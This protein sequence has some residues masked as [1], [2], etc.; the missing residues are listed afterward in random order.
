MRI[1]FGILI[2][3]EAAA[4]QNVTVDITPSHVANTFSPMHALGSG[5]DAVGQGVVDQVYTPSNI[6][7]MLSAGWGP[8]TY[9]LYTELS[10]QHWHWNPQGSWS[11]PNGQGYWS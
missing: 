1:V 10:V 11:A 8:L 7:Q 3:L 9:R 2:V 6:S 4:A 5:V